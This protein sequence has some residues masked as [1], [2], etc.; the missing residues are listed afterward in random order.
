M[1]KTV[2]WFAFTIAL[3]A[4]TAGTLSAA[5]YSVDSSHSSV[6]FRTKRFDTVNFYGRFN[7]LEGKLKFDPQDV[8]ASS[9]EL[10]IKAEA[11]DTAN[12][13]RD[14]HLRSPDFFDAKQ[15]PVIQFKSSQ[16]SSLGENRL[17]ITGDLTMHG[18][19]RTIIAKATHV[20][21]GK[22]PRRGTPLIGFETTFTI[23]RT[24]FG[25]D[26]MVGA[27]SDEVQ[28]TIAIQGVAGE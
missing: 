19:T 21:S 25:M 4:L 12:Q 28:V 15:F 9:V 6:V 10:E 7:G 22:H 13:R 26:Y 16:V 18:V 27:L 14:D 3:F 2:R 5:E 24:D 20:G 17:E 23:K 11:V 1:W 8:A